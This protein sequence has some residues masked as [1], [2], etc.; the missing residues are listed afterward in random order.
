VDYAGSG[1]H[2]LRF[3]RLY[4]SRAY[5]VD[6]KVWR[7]SYSS[8]INHQTFGTVPVVLTHRANGRTFSFVFNGSA[9]VPDVDIDDR[10]T[11]LVDGSGNHTGWQYYEASSE[12]LETYDAQGRLLSI[13]DRAGLSH[14]LSYTGGLLTQ[15][16]DAFGRTLSFTYDARGR[17][18][19]MRDPAGQ[20]Y[21]YTWVSQGGVVGVA[22][23]PDGK[24]RQ[25][26]YNEA[27]WLGGSTREGRLTGIVDENNARY[28]SFEH[29][30]GFALRTEHA[31]GVNR[32]SVAN[33]GGW[34]NSVVV[35]DPLG[36]VRTYGY[37]KFNEV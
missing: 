24:T 15:V 4:L 5:N 6:G 25:Y 3:Q 29:S 1:P 10:L 12:N 23:Y 17:M 16:T 37:Q 34:P 2:P 9:Y 19:T 27:G 35:T 11:K 7:H 31:G 22:Y 33:T 30:H 21:T 18:L 36:T 28:A 13:A 26:L 32:Y 20:T 14:T 8:W